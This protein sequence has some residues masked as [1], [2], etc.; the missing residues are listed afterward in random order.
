MRDCLTSSNCS[1]IDQTLILQTVQGLSCRIA[2]LDQPAA[3]GTEVSERPLLR[4]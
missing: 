4:A 1:E 3:V 2:S